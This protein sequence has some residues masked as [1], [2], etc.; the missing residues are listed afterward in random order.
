MLSRPQIV[1]GIGIVALIAAV[2]ATWYARVDSG[3]SAAVEPAAGTTPGAPLPRLEDAAGWINGPPLGADSLRGRPIVLVLWSD[4]DPRSLRAL[5]DAEAWHQAYARYGVRVIGIHT[6]EFAFAADSAVAARA[7]RRA[8][9][10]FPIA[11]DPQYRVR[12][13]LGEVPGTPL[14]LFADD[15]GEIRI[16]GG[17]EHLPQIDPA[18]REAVR[19]E[20][21]ELAFPAEPA[22][23]VSAS[24]AAPPPRFVFLG[25][26]RVAGGPLARALPGQ[27]QTFTAQFRYQE[28]G[29]PFV[30]Y[31]VGRWT[32]S[33]EGLTA[34]RGGAANFVS[35]RY[36]GGAVSA[37]MTPPAHGPVRVWI[38]VADGWLAESE[39]GEDVR[40]DARG[41]TYV[42]VV[43]PRL[44]AIARGVARA[45]KLSP[46]EPGVTID[47]FVIEPSESGASP[48]P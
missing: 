22:V 12:R 41:A 47:S 31:P 7:A 44:Y 32:P 42:D 24:H 11:L 21:P 8:H 28:E 16:R 19:R 30:P 18:L 27:A 36:E 45:L 35:M 37:V 48:R 6:P 5:A 3:R 26:A 43:E 38:L 9:A 40:A 17:P 25:T 10:T 20:H 39:R 4:T 46:E 29:E 14:I 15:T 23:A 13:Q 2:G 34:A 33:A 1:W